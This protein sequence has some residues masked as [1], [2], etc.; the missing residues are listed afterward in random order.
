[1]AC[2]GPAQVLGIHMIAGKLKGEDG[3]YERVLHT[4]HR[5]RRAVGLAGLARVIQRSGLFMYDCGYIGVNSKH[6]WKL[7]QRIILFWHKIFI[8]FPNVYYPWTFGRLFLSLDPDV[9]I[10]YMLISIC[11]PSPS[12]L[13]SIPDRILYGEW[14]STICGLNSGFCCWL[15]PYLLTLSTKCYL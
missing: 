12:N 10:A 14:H 5:K 4:A 1:M 3:R 11:R 2:G 15:T 13:T 8:V 6:L 9:S 7:D